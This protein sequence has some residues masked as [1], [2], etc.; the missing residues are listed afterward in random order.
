MAKIKT[1]KIEISAGP[2]ALIVGSSEITVALS[3]K[4]QQG[5]CEVVEAGEYP[6]SG[7]FNYIF[8]FGKVDIVKDSHIKFLK[9]YGKFLFIDYTGE[10]IS[11]ITGLSGVKILRVENLNP[12]YFQKITDEILKITF[13]E[14]DKNVSDIRLKPSFGT[15]KKVISEK[16]FLIKKEDP[17]QTDLNL[18]ESYVEKKLSGNIIYFF[19]FILIFFFSITGFLYWQAKSALDIIFDTQDSFLTSDYS[20]VSKN[21]EKINEKLKLVKIIY[22]IA[23]GPLSPLKN[24]TFIVN[25]GQLLDSSEEFLKTSQFLLSEARNLNNRAAAQSSSAAFLSEGDFDSVTDKILKLSSSAKNL[26]QKIKFIN[27]PGIPLDSIDTFLGS[28]ITESDSLV[29]IFPQLKK[30]LYTD[31]KNYLILFQNNME[32]RPTGGFI[33]SVGFLTLNRGN[34]E[35]FEILDV[36]S[37][38]GQLKGHVDPPEVFRIHFQQPNWFLRDSNF[39]PDFAASALQAQWFLEKSINRKVDGVI[40]MNLFLVQDLIKAVGGVTLPDFNNEVITNDNFFIKAQLYINENFFAGSNAKRNYLNSVSVQ[41]EQKLVSGDVSYLEVLRVFKKALDEKNIIFFFND[42]SFQLDMEKL[43]W[44]GRV[45]DIGCININDSCFP[46]Y[47]YINEANF[48]VNKANYFITKSIK[49]DKKINING[50]IITD[51]TLKFRNQSQNGLLQGGE[52]K[53]Y[54]RL[55]LPRNS[56]MINSAINNQI[57]NNNLYEVSSYQKDKT[58]YGILLKIPENSELELKFSY[59][60]SDLLK[61]NNLYY[62]FYFQKQPGDKISS[63]DLSFASS[64]LR[65]SPYNFISQNKDNSV[66]TLSTDTSVDRIF[67]LRLPLE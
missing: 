55:I 17:A 18:K 29:Q 62:Q 37:I 20:S 63:L 47:L 15:H 41:L 45:Y 53:N 24:L 23:A 39:D 32:L 26:R 46:D 8:Q 31:K 59:L 34:I 5:G 36:Y 9:P 2:L 6:K 42:P 56:Q 11:S 10:N 13:T 22:G 43:A 12:W 58:I 65:I 48:G 16:T 33:G 35:N 49:V 60:L 64:K 28:F 14:S 61:T 50:Q 57:I 44:A 40:G 54:L 67:Q 27:F 52:Y 66:L 7:K 25:T 4:L 38:D 19:I 30:I 21:L 51:L 1:E 3:R